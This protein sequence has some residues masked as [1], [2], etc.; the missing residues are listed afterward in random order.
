MPA[1]RAVHQ[2]VSTAPLCSGLARRPLKAVARVRIPSGLREAEGPPSRRAFCHSWPVVDVPHSRF[3]AAFVTALTRVCGGRRSRSVGP[4]MLTAATTWPASSWTGAE[5]EATPGSRCAMVCAQPR[6]RT[7]ARSAAREGGTP[8]E[9]CPLVLR[10]PGDQHLRRGAGAKG[11]QRPHRHRVPQARDGLGCGDA[12]PLVPGASVDLGA[13][14]AGV[15]EFGDDG[16]G[17]PTPI[18]CG[19]G[20][21][22]DVRADGEPAVIVADQ[23]PVALE[24]HG[25]PVGGRAGE[26]GRLDQF[27][28][29]ERGRRDGIEH[30]HGLV[31]DTDS[32]RVVHVVILMSHIVRCQACE[33]HASGI[34]A[35]DM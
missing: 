11:E 31:N 21:A 8:K 13:L 27:G 22:Q 26:T 20:P 4:E 29:A 9:S 2:H 35:S 24:G 5:I 30:P 6:R 16:L 15:A 1:A 23:H 34:H 12:Q 3:R 32:A 19:C 25:D 10:E 28:E 14:A 7:A 17:P 33:I 18:V